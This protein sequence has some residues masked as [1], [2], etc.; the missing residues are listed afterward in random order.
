MIEQEYIFHRNAAD[1]DSAKIRHCD[2]DQTWTVESYDARVS[3]LMKQ[4]GAAELKSDSSA[5][6]F[7]VNAKQLIEFI[8]ETNGLIVEFRTRRRA[9]LSP[10]Q[11]EAKRQRMAELRARQLE[12]A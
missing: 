7:K 11:I 10:E 9:Q 1:D 5:R 3:K 6:V 2:N 12:K 4:S 8:A